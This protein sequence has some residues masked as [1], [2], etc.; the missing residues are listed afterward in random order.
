MINRKFDPYK[1]F[2]NPYSPEG[3][4]EKKTIRNRKLMEGPKLGD[5]I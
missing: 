2:K 1:I 5:Y 3:I 4:P